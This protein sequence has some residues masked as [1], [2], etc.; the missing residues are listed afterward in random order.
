MAGLSE[1][2]VW[3]SLLTT[4]L[5]NYR[6]T[7]IDNIFDTY[8]L[9]SWLNGKLGQ[10]MRG[11]SLKRILDGGDSI[12]EQLMYGT[13]STVKSYSGAETLDTTL[14]EGLTIARYAWKQY[15]ATVGITGLERR[16]NNG[17]ASMLNLIKAK[18][19]QAEMS[20]RDR[21]NQDAFSDGT[22]NSS[23]NLT[24]LQAIVSTTGTLGSLSPTTY[25]WWAP[26]S[27]SCGSFAANG[28]S[29]MRTLFNTLSLGNDKPDFIITTQTAFEYY[30]SALQPQERY[31]DSK[32][33]NSG[34][35]NLTFKGVPLMFD[36]DCPSGKLYA[37][38][39]NYLNFVVHRDADFTLGDM[40]KPIGQDV[41]SAQLLFMGNMT[42]SNRRMQGELTGITA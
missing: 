4:T 26:T 31:T 32:L 22:G 10:T 27:T 39:S 37:L 16:S 41:V 23:K 28:L 19:K 30:E 33:A 25:T 11:S 14:Q 34:W 24:G 38:N 18:T 13:N 21:M 1:T 2:R 35:Q 36:R 20:L 42:C 17:E 12:V 3:D 8:P 7:L 9:L 6:N 29:K 15:S 40:Q 5:A